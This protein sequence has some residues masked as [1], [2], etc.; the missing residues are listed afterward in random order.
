VSPGGKENQRLWSK[1]S[2]R[3]PIGRLVR[4]G[5]N[6][7]RFCVGFG[8]FA[9]ASSL[10]NPLVE[11]KLRGLALLRISWSSERPREDKAADQCKELIVQIRLSI[12]SFEYH[13]SQAKA[14]SNYASP[15]RSKLELIRCYGLI[16][17]LHLVPL[18]PKRNIYKAAELLPRLAGGLKQSSTSSTSPFHRRENKEAPSVPF[19]ALCRTN[20]CERSSLVFSYRPFNLA[21]DFL[22][23]S[24]PGGIA[25]RCYVDVA[26]SD[27]DCFPERALLNGIT[28]SGPASP[29]SACLGPRTMPPLANAST[30]LG[31]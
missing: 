13:P 20:L 5:V 15:L 1:V 26:E 17:H 11:T 16:R 28:A 27:I 4:F 24:S 12:S 7:K 31:S 29:I 23:R 2:G 18:P 30:L 6:E 8:S 3:H 21:N 10:E 19:M 22:C 25:S 14:L 9:I